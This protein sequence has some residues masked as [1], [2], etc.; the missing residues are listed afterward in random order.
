MIENSKAY[1]INLDKR[2]D[3]LIKFIENIS[4]CGFDPSTITRLSA[5]EDTDF[6]GVGCAKSH[7]WALTDF[8][9]N[10]SQKYCIVLEDDFRF[11]KSKSELND[12]LKKIEFINPLF[13]VFLLTCLQPI[14]FPIG[15]GEVHEIFEGHC[16][17]GYIVSREYTPTLLSCFYRSIM[18]MEKYRN[19]Q[20]RNLIY[21]RFA[22]DQDW[23]K[24]QREGGWYSTVPQIGTHEASYSD[25]EHRIK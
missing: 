21:D 2:T 5:I 18:M 13:K 4:E 17:A 12:A 23:K 6:G 7:V 19:K 11:I 10:S 1:L 3:R 15:V 9:V 24:Y 25:I 16:T 14:S 22:I 20:P 8:I